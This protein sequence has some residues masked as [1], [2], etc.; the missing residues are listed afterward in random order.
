MDG[1]SRSLG[2]DEPVEFEKP[3]VKAHDFMKITDQFRGIHGVYGSRFHKGK[4]KDVNM[5]PGRLD[6]GTRLGSWLIVLPK[7]SRDAGN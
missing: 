4:L 3:P 1:E 7:I 2:I 6:L 5:L